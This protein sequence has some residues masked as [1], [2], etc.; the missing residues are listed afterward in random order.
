MRFIKFYKKFSKVLIAIFAVCSIALLIHEK[1]VVKGTALTTTEFTVLCA[2]C[3][4]AVVGGVVWIAC[5]YAYERAIDRRL[6]G[7]K[8]V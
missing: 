4:I 3:A 2:A 1:K 7:G 5:E 6:M 8:R